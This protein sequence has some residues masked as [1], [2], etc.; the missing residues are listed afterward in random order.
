[1]SVR[2]DAGSA[3]SCGRLSPVNPY[4]I[5]FGAG[6]RVINLNLEKQIRIS[7]KDTYVK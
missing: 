1:M 6:K 2:P 4:R 7:S 5:H 3:A